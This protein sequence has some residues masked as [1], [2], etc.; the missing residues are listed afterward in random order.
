MTCRRSALPFVLA[1]TGLIAACQAGSELEQGPAATPSGLAAKAA[2]PTTN[3]PEQAPQPSRIDWAAAGDCLDALWLLHTAAREGRLDRAERPPVAVVTPDVPPVPGW[4]R[5][6]TVPVAADLPLEVRDAASMGGLAVPCVVQIERA[7]D[8]RAEH[9]VL[10]QEVVRSL[11]QSGV[12]S[13]KKRPRT[14]PARAGDRRFE[15]GGAIAGLHQQG[16]G[17]GAGRGAAAGEP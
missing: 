5:A 2:T 7:H 1:G 17:A 9:R 4:Y 3:A 10:G 15:E 8:Q 6:T 12:R 13:E 14:V 16:H 11:Y